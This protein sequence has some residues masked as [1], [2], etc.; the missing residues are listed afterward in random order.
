ML[1]GWGE[2]MCNGSGWD[3]SE[4]SSKQIEYE[5]PMEFRTVMQEG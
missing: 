4:L 2:G 1:G 3:R 5:V